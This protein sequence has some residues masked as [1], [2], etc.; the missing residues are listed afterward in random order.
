MDKTLESLVARIEELEKKVTE[1]NKLTQKIDKTIAKI[2]AGAS[3]IGAR[4]GFD[5]DM[6]FYVGVGSGRVYRTKITKRL[7]DMIERVNKLAPDEICELNKLFMYKDL[8]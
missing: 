3:A 4:Y 5:K 2:D 7:V 1:L 6:A 8:K